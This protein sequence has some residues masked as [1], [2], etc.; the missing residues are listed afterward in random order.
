MKDIKFCRKCGTK[1]IETKIGLENVEEVGGMGE[2]MIKPYYP[3]DE[4][5][6][7]RNYGIERK[8]P[9]LS[10]PFGGGHENFKFNPK[11]K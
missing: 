11:D 4:K 2:N 9:N 10:N 7:K 5:T 6:G 8:C 1:L 3:Y